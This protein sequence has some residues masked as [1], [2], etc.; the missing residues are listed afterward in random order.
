MTRSKNDRRLSD[1][2]PILRKDKDGKIKSGTPDD[3]RDRTLALR[4]CRSSPVH[5]ALE[6]M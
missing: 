5:T 3:D 2:L 1:P 6:T 4:L